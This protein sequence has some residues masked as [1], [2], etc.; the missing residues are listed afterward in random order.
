MCSSSGTRRVPNCRHLFLFHDLSLKKNTSSAT[1]KAGT[2]HP[3]G[4]HDFILWTALNNLY[5]NHKDMIYFPV[6]LVQQIYEH[7]YSI[8][9]NTFMKS[10]RISLVKFVV[11]NETRAKHKILQVWFGCLRTL[12]AI[13]QLYRG[14]EFYWWRKP[15]ASEKTTYLPQVTDKLYHIVQNNISRI[16]DAN[17]FL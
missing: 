8:N 7:Q 9:N 15:E 6:L 1:S 14:G 10:N 2:V 3:S 12:S 13:F 16:Y 5:S 4:T 17:N 11:G